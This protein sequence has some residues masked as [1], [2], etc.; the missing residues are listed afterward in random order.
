[1]FLN[2]AEKRTSALSLLAQLCDQF[3]FDA[4]A[5]GN[6]RDAESASGMWTVFAVDLDEKLRSTIRN[7]M[8]LCEL[9]SAV[10]QDQEF[11]DARDFVEVP[12]CGMQ[13]SHQLDRDAA[14]SFFSLG[15]IEFCS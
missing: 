9:R 12:G 1:M 6:L 7:E 13:R 15:G 4:G 11:N 10:D 2:R 3:Y 5:K 8:L 14:G